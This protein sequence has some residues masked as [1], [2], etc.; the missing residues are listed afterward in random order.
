MHWEILAIGLVIE[1]I[2]RIG[3]RGYVVAE[4]DVWQPSFERAETLAY[5]TIINTTSISAKHYFRQSNYYE[6]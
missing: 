3:P 4:Q 2:L 6:D 1:M 5:R